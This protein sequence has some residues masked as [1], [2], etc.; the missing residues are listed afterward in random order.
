LVRQFRA[1]ADEARHTHFLQEH[2]AE[3]ALI[4][5]HYMLRRIVMMPA[6]FFMRMEN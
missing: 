6:H 5:V 4:L 2:V 1:I 3:A